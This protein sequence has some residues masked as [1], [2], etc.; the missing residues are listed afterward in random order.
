MTAAPQPSVPARSLP[1]EYAG[2]GVASS[3]TVLD[4][5]AR[6]WGDRSEGDRRQL[7]QILIMVLEPLNE[8]GARITEE[9][10]AACE[11]VVTEWVD[12]T[13]PAG[14]QPAPAALPVAP[15]LKARRV[16]L[17]E[18]EGGP[19]TGGQWSARVV[20]QVG[21]RRHAGV[22]SCQEDSVAQLHCAGRAT[23]QALRQAVPGLPHIELKK[24]ETFEA[25][26]SLGVIVALRIT[27]GDEQNTLVG[28]CPNT[29]PDI[30]RAVATAVLNATNRRLGTG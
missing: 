1:D 15:A 11:Q 5:V 22:D 21:A 19:S 25:F 8:P 29:G 26:E 16:R 23:I 10:R 30:V 7:A 28:V 20:L 12:K 17:V 6:R 9:L 24:L 2:L 3:D 4:L 18:T 13:A 14:S 27:E